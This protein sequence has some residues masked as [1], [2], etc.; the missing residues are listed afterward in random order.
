MTSEEKL[1]VVLKQKGMRIAVAESC[2]GGLVGGRITGVPGSSDYFEAGMVTYS[3]R[4]KELFLSVPHEVIAA[5]GSVS[6]EVAELMARGVRVAT[7]VD[8]GVAVTGIAG[9]GGGSPEKPVGLVYIGLATPEATITRKY[10]FEG[11]RAAVRQQTS[12]EALKLVLEVL[13]GRPA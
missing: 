8:I 9:P 13:E 6:P 2:T 11:D 5:K 7:G 3:N 12:E 4:A 10:R 1:G